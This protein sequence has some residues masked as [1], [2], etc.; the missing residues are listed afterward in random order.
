M[1]MELSMMEIRWIELL[2]DETNNSTLNESI[3]ER[4]EF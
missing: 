1:N 4:S 2:G 3:K